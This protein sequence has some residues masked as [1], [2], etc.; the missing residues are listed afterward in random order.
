ME[1]ILEELTTHLGEINDLESINALL[2]WDQIT[3]MPPQGATARGRQ[4]ATLSTLVHT[5]H[6]DPAIGRL[7][8][9]LHTYEEQLPYESDEASLIRV[10]RRDYEQWIRVPSAFIAEFSNHLSESYTAWLA[11]REANN[12]TVVQ[13]YVEKTLELS[14][15]YSTFF[16][17]HDHSIDPLIN[18]SDYG[19]SAAT[20]RSLFT[21]LRQHLVP[22]VH[23]ISEQ[24]AI[25]DSC[26]HQYFPE[27]QQLAFGNEVIQRLGY[28]FER[29][30][31]DKTVHPFMTKFS[32]GD[33]RITT[34]IDE[35][36]LNEALFS[37]IHEAGHALYEQGINRAFERT[38]LAVGTSSGV[39]ESQSRLWE[40]M[41]GRSEPFWHYFY[42]RLQAAFPQQLAHVPIT[43]FY[44]AINKVACSLIRTDADEVTYNLHAMLRFDLELALLEGTLHICDLPEAWNARYQTDLGIV[45]SDDRMGVLQDIH[46][47]MGYIGGAFQGYT[48]GNILSAQ[49]FE[50]AQKAHPTITSEIA[51]GEFDTLHNWL[52]MHIY[53]HGRKFTAD[54]IVAQATGQP[55]SIEPYMNYLRSKY[56]KLYIL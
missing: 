15:Q 34:R 53:A 14:R 7:L 18:L 41:V 52:R 30:R 10:A 31:Q 8:E 38:P 42:P 5:K 6:T 35:N 37:T 20:I 1:T 36:Y 48:I 54:E 32:L 17:G 46:W 50:A 16:P 26:L 9:K 22:I 44:R 24:P 23:A 28:D 13:P 12:F 33:V 43:T 39:H 55:L 2:E 3:Y 27:D 25:D 29:G 51:Q 4:M 49:F 45:P 19:M 11:A 56:E 40:N 47:Y 21:E